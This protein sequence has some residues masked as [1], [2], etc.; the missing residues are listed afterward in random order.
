MGI[1][2]VNVF[3]ALDDFDLSIGIVVDYMHGILLG[4]AKTMM[5]LWFLPKNNKEDFFIGMHVSIDILNII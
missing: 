2:G 3:M 1:K 4:V 5:E